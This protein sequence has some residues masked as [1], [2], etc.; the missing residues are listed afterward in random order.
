LY[1]FRLL[2]ESWI[3]SSLIQLRIR[4]A[5]QEPVDFRYEVPGYVFEPALSI[6]DAL[7]WNSRDRLRA[8]LSGQRGTNSGASLR[9]DDNHRLVGPF[10]GR[11]QGV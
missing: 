1:N 6:L 7:M 9:F 3:V 4:L 10:A 5:I 8:Y 2:A 11:G